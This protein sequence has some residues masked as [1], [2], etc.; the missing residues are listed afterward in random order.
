MTIDHSG[1]F[2]SNSLIYFSLLISRQS[3]QVLNLS[4]FAA[5][6][7]RVQIGTYQGV[8]TRKVVKG[9]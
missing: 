9:L 1:Y 6:L 3:I 8:V 4:G 5:G 2:C 7:Y